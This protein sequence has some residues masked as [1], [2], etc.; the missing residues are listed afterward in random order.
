MNA[1]DD[2]NSLT[3]PASRSASTFPIGCC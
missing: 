1:T 3:H 2:P